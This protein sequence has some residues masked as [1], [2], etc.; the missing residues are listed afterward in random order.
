MVLRMADNTFIL[1]IISPDRVFY[2]GE[3]KMVEMVTSEGEIGVLKGHI[4]MTNILKPGI[5]NIYEEDTRKQA[6]LHGGFVEILQ[7]K[8]T[9]LA[10]IAEWPDEIDI[11]RA[12]EAKLRAE[13]RLSEHGGGIDTLRAEAALKKALV[14]IELGAKER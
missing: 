11:N 10:E 14:R 4:P 6:A 5:I 8:V 9:V 3:V 13:R 12:N 2:E 1:Q 7:E